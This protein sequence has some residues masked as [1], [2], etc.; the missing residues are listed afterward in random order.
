MAERSF[1]RLS[2]HRTR[3]LARVLQRHAAHAQRT[4]VRKVGGRGTNLVSW[5]A[6]KV[7]GHV[8]G[9]ALGNQG[10]GS[11][12]WQGGEGATVLQP[13]DGVC[14]VVARGEA[15]ELQRGVHH[16]H[17]GDPGCRDR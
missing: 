12:T 5:G 4:A 14:E 1:P 3:V 16:R 8:L 10:A 2:A 15:G 9:S 11:F 13:A 6:D 17:G 7:R